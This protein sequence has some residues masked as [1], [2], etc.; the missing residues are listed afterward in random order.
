[1]SHKTLNTKRTTMV[2]R[3]LLP[4]KVT[5]ILELLN[6]GKWHDTEE[7]QLRLELSEREFGEIEAFLAEYDFIKADPKNRR[8]KITRDFRKLL[9]QVHTNC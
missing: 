7:M 3:E 4:S 5:M 6:D 2:R 8:V 9:A 1:M